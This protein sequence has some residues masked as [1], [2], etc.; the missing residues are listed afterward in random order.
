MCIRDRGIGIESVDQTTHKGL[1]NTT[2][3]IYN[4]DN[5]Q[6]FHGVT[7]ASGQIATGELPSGRYTIR[8]MSTPDG[9]TAVE[10]MKTITLGSKPVTVVFEQ[11]AHTSLIIELVDDASGAPLAGSRF[12]V[13]SIDGSYPTT[14]VTGSDGTVIIGGLAAGRLSLI[15]I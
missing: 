15:H 9:Y 13:E 10:T 5:I 1:A 7:D 4:E 3:E 11:K 6:G 8:Q 2:F 12:R 14:V